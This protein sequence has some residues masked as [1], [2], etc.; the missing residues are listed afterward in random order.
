MKTTNRIGM[1]VF[2]VI[3]AVGCGGDSSAASGAAMMLSAGDSTFQQSANLEFKDSAGTTYQLTTAQVHLRKVE[4]ESKGS[5]AGD[6]GV[7]DDDSDKLEDSQHDSSGDDHSGCTS[8]DHETEIQGPFVVD[9]VRG[10]ATPAINI[11]AG[12]YHEI[13]FKIE[14]GDPE[15]GLVAVGSPL[16]DH[17]FYAEA[18]FEHAGQPLQL[19][20]ALDFDA[21]L[22]LESDAGIT[23]DGSSQHVM[24]H[25][26]AA[27]WLQGV[28]IGACLDSGALVA[29]DGVVRVSDRD[30]GSSDN[31]CSHIGKT[32]EENIKKHIAHEQEKEHEGEDDHDDDSSSND[33]HQDDHSTQS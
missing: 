33:D 32:I 12:T 2:A 6:A 26:A 9:L 10:T 18:A 31:G 28:D 24:V 13:K 25:M 30:G 7:C 17:S 5:T 22:E 1:S 8:D 15:D 3:G 14:D 29:T 27:N 16:D 4:L 23:V 19:H 11:P 20:V 21:E